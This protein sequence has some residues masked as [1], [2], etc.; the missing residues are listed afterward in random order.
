MK[1]RRLLAC[2]LCLMLPLSAALAGQLLPDET[3]TLPGG[4]LPSG[5]T[6]DVNPALAAC[7]LDNNAST[8]WSRT[9]IRS[10]EGADL[11][12][13]PAEG[14]VAAIWLR[15]GNCA[16]STSYSVCARPKVVRVSI[17]YLQRGA[18][19][20][21]EYRYALT[22]A[23]KPYSRE[24]LWYDG[25]QCLVLPLPFSGVQSVALTV[26]S[27]YAGS[28]WPDLI[29]LSDV[30]LSSQTP[31]TQSVSIP[32]AAPVPQTGA[33]V[34]TWL[35]MRLATRSGPSTRYDELG[36]YFEAGHEIRVLSLCYDDNDLPWVQVEFT[37][38]NELRRAYTGLKRVDV[39]ASELRE[40][41]ALCEARLTDQ[42]TPRYGPGRDYT[43]RKLT[44][45]KGLEGTVFAYENGWAQL[46]YYDEDGEV[47]R[48]VW[49][50]EEDLLTLY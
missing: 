41:Y 32:T 30:L 43:A 35:L 21:S 29:C 31:G 26:E 17:T 24:T 5:V 20:T 34:D 6:A 50:P 12:F 2:L 40:E 8:Y 39:S 49:V 45:P 15:S 7:L 9:G 33:P 44:L 48:R 28:I 13:V 14:T 36:S 18:L 4:S 1:L 47:W 19:L 25:Y 42:V 37:Y 11:L 46:E 23:F 10:T 3:V 27:C 38:R 22:D 16:D